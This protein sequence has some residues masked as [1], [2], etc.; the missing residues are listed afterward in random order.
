MPQLDQVG[1]DVGGTDDEHLAALG[2]PA[3]RTGA[4]PFHALAFALAVGA[5]GFT[6]SPSATGW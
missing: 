3:G 5:E 6:F 2:T 1:G 4:F